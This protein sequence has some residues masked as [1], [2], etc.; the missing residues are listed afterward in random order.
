ML[1]WN[2]AVM[3]YGWKAKWCLATAGL[4]AHNA[5]FSAGQNLSSDQ[6]CKCVLCQSQEVSLL[7]QSPS[8]ARGACTLL[9]RS[10]SMLF[11][12]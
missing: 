4:V 7:R 1:C 10:G 9:S 3:E 8:C 11:A 12:V 2:G 6:D 5:V